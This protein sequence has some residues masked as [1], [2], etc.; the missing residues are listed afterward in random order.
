M[1]MPVLEF[2][3][4]FAQCVARHRALQTA[5]RG[6]LIATMLSA[7]EDPWWIRPAMPPLEELDFEADPLQMPRLMCDNAERVFAARADYADDYIPYVSPRYG[8]GIIGG[9]LLGVMHFGG[10][11]S[12]TIV[13][14]DSLEAALDFPWGRENIWIDRVI[15]AL[16]YMAQRMSGKAYTFLEGYHTPLE[17]AAEIRGSP[18]YL[19]LVMQPDKVHALL[20]R[21]DEALTWLYTLLAE[22]VKKHE[23]G[24]LAHSLWM[25]R[26]IPFLSDDSSGLIS[27]AHYAE[28]G[29]PYTNAMFA[30]FGGGFLHVHTLAYHQMDNLS[31]MRSMTLYN[32]R[33]D[34]NTPEPAR[35]LKTI[36]PGAQHK[37]VTLALSPREI[38]ENAGLLNQG[39]FF[40][41]SACRDRREQEAI[42]R[43][44]HERLQIR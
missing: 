44:V 42:I 21:C 32:W 34:P 6:C 29:A 36:V 24:A 11:T 41:F 8:T 37:I 19:D 26:C 22:R 38:R 18:L 33:L 35:I 23:Y 40:L 25:E 2:K 3:R 16:N 9:M 1:P 20:K 39:R 31:R 43:F 4:N 13:K 17:W 12:W 15:Q 14:T 10:N 28:F 7:D 27:P 5:V 30:R